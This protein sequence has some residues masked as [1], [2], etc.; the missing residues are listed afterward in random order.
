MEQVWHMPPGILFSLPGLA[1]LI[2]LWYKKPAPGV[3]KQA[4]FSHVHHYHLDSCLD[5]ISSST[6]LDFSTACVPWRFHAQST[7]ASPGG[8]IPS[9]LELAPLPSVWANEETVGSWLM[10][11]LERHIKNCRGSST[12]GIAD[13]FTVPTQDGQSHLPWH[14]YR[15]RKS[16]SSCPLK[17]HISNRLCTINSALIVP[18]QGAHQHLPL[19]Y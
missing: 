14:H 1:A 15:L 16:L 4:N 6:S 8:P 10:S 17:R 7:I 5:N 19:H 11:P 2:Y 18:T 3:Y 13:P 12:T 9:R